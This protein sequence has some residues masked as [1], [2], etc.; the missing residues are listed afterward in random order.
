MKQLSE[1]SSKA[2]G[3]VKNC[4]FTRPIEL[5]NQARCTVEQQFLDDIKLSRKKEDVRKLFRKLPMN[6]ESRVIKKTD[7][8][9]NSDSQAWN[10]KM[11]K[12]R[13]TASPAFLQN[14]SSSAS[15]ALGK[16]LTDALIAQGGDDS[17]SYTPIVRNIFPIAYRGIYSHSLF[18]NY[19]TEDD[20]ARLML[21]RPTPF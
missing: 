4:S 18:R 9:W 14:G 12:K 21:Q 11:D 6:G 19:F 15:S 16:W 20:F 2:S 8:K 10:M 7:K 17:V 1:L 5:R 3:E 13:E